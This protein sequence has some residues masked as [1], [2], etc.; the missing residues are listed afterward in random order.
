MIEP[1]TACQSIEIFIADNVT[2][3]ENTA[4]EALAF[5]IRSNEGLR[6]PGQGIPTITHTT[7]RIGAQAT[8]CSKA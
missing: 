7:A 8:G 5:A 6:Y 1:N 3:A 2:P 4:I